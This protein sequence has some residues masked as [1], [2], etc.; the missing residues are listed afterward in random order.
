M[1]MK[2]YHL[3]Q[4]EKDSRYDEFNTINYFLYKETAEQVKSN[5]DNN[6]FL[7]YEIKEIEVVCN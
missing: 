4:R 5:I 6:P 2:I 7:I 3:I 1:I